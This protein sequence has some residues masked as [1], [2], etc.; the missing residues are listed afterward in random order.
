[1]RAMGSRRPASISRRMLCANAAVL[2]LAFVLLAVTPVTVS[3]RIRGAELAILLAGG[4]AMLIIGWLLVRRALAPLRGLSRQMG[5]I[6]LKQGSAP[7]PFPGSQVREVE[8][9]TRA[10]SVMVDRLAEERLQT[11]RAVLAGQEGERLRV[12]RELHDE[13]GQGLI[14]IALMAERAAAA[15]EPELSE[16]FRDIAERLHFYLDELR[17]IAHELRPEMLDDLGLV[18]AL[19]ALANS[20]AADRGLPVKRE[21]PRSTVGLTTEQELVFYR[22][23]QEALTNA[24]RHAA[25]ST[26]SVHLLEAPGAL[27]LEVLDDGR[28]IGAGHGDGVGIKGMRE[29]ARL[30]GG[31]LAIGPGPGSGTRVTLTLPLGETD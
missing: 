12:A 24:A 2:A 30:V 17:R 31:S 16:Q 11:A 14:A 8:S 22:V 5:Q 18:N 3:A 6:D 26:V 27:V 23:A 25:A 15:A 19:I 7:L 9:V 1:M 20:V 29:R 10:L 13:V 28:G 21:L 4:V